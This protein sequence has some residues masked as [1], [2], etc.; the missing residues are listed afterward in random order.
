VTFA[1]LDYVPLHHTAK[2]IAKIFVDYFKPYKSNTQLAQDF[3]QPLV[4]MASL[5]I[6]LGKTLFGIF[7]LKPGYLG[8]GVFSMLRGVIELSTTPL[9]YNSTYLALKTHYTRN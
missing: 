2:K 3:R 4:G 1:Q 9:K 8:D 5:F 6:G 7:T